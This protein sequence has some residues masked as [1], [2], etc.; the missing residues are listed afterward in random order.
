MPAAESPRHTETMGQRHVCRP[1]LVLLL[2][3]GDLI[4]MA[5]CPFSC[6]SSSQANCIRLHGRGGALVRRG[7]GPSSPKRPIGPLVLAWAADDP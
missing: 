4:N 7:D 6:R 5:P 1:T 2:A 3:M